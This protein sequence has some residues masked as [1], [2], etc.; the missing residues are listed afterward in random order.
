METK[1]LVKPDYQIIH[2]IDATVKASSNVPVQSFYAKLT[3][4]RRCPTSDLTA[5]AFR[6]FKFLHS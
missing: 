6:T 5:A 1:V 3:H 4:L 2:G